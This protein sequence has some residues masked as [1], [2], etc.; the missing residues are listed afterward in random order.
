MLWRVP[1]SLFL[2]FGSACAAVRWTTPT[3]IPLHRSDFADVKF[4]LD[5]ATAQKLSGEGDAFAAVQAALNS[6]NALPNTALHFAP[7]QTGAANLVY[8]DGQNVI[9]FADSDAVKGEVGNNIAITHLSYNPDG[10][11]LE[12]DIILNPNLRF[13]MTLK[14]GTYDLQSVITHELGHALGA[15]HATVAGAAMFWNIMQGDNATSTLKADDAQF[16]TDVYPAGNAGFGTISG[17]VSKDGSAVFGAGV[18][19]VD[20]DTGITIGGMTSTTDGSFTLRVP[21]GNYLV[22]A[23]PIAPLTPL[24]VVYGV[25]A[26]KIGTAF[27]AAQAPVRQFINAGSTIAVNIAVRSGASALS[28]IQVAGVLKSGFGGPVIQA[29]NSLDVIAVGPGLD[30]SITEDDLELIGPSAIIHSGSLRVDQS[31]TFSD[32]T[33]PI[34]FTIDTTMVGQSALLSLL[35][36]HGPDRAF[37]PGGITVVPPKPAFAAAGIVNAASSQGAAVAPGELVT[38][39]GVSLGPPAPVLVS[40]FDPNTGGLPVSL[41][42]VSVTFDGVPAPILFASANQINL[43]A[44]YEIAGK[45]ATTVVVNYQGISSDPV[46]IRVTAAQPGLFLHGSQAVA[47]NQDGSLN[48]ATNAAPK[49]SWV[50]IYAT[51][52]GMTSPQLGTGQPAAVNPLSFAQDVAATIGGVAANV[53]QGGVLAPGFVGLLQAGVQIPANVPSGTADIVLSVAGQASPTAKISVE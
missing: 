29:G 51:G 47:L 6:W 13:S 53:Y 14:P 50:T 36:T 45:N 25:P 21:T 18:I 48:S 41:A 37:L 11:I 5:S 23:A 20:P 1:V 39:Y 9:A 15:N 17:T 26:S 2:V 4:I 7:L 49:G 35:I 46:Q 22:F 3:G 12:S 42:G 8:G 10:T 33:H 30:D 24:Q 16:A 27:E 19:A 32:G 43:Q 40:G 28:L 38:L 52:A 34:R 44:P 31:I